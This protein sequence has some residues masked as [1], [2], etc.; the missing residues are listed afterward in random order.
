M[1]T[2]EDIIVIAAGGHGRVVLDALLTGGARVRGLI[3][4]GLVVGSR[5]FDVPVL[6]GDEILEGLAVEDCLL[7]N[8]LGAN[9]ST[10]ARAA[11]HQRLAARGFRF[12]RVIH[13]SAIVGRE[14]E[15]GEGCQLMAGAVVQCGVRIGRNAVVNTAASLDHDVIVGDDAF[16][17]P[18]ATLCG[19]VALGHCAFVG[20]GATVLPSVRV[21]DGA[22]VAAGAIVRRD[23]PGGETH[24][25]VPARVQR[26]G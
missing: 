9:P 18:G 6:G 14:V 1:T 25:G 17:A 23:V 8:G 13:P 20:A 5:I 2:G 15:L 7:A 10:V 4:P 3:D 24:V 11:L 19:N 26:K 12:A 22:V 16:I 21:G